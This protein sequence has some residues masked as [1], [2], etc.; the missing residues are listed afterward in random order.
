MW[1]YFQEERSTIRVLL[2]HD[3]SLLSSSCPVHHQAQL[4]SSSKS[5]VHIVVFLHIYWG[6]TVLMQIS[7]PQ[8]LAQGMHYL[9]EHEP[10]LEYEL[11]IKCTLFF[12]IYAGESCRN[13]KFDLLYGN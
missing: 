3:I 5:G 12:Q 6:K 4:F 2:E 13:E 10:R 9:N 11:C 7:C 8:A 1:K